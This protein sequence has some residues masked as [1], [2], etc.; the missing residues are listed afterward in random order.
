MQ[1]LVSVANLAEARDAVAGGAD[2]VDA[3]DPSTGALG[4]VTLDTLQEIHAAVGGR[5]VV[6]AALGDAT[7]ERRI[8][9]LAFDYASTGVGF[10]KVGFAG[11]T[12]PSCVERLMRAA[13]RGVRASALR[14]CG[15]IAVAYADSSGSGTTSVES[16]ALIDI[17]ARAG[18]G[19]VLLDT[20]DKRG[21]GLLRHVPR[22]QLES[23]VARAH[24]ARLTVALAGKLTASDLPLICTI[25]ADIAGVRG[26][27]CEDGRSSR[28]SVGKVRRL[29]ES[30]VG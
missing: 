28:V 25:G 23:W 18:A 26:A 14:N 21:P 24:E 3:K 5:R 9:H 16:T 17:A 11:V 7:D 29:T 22:A 20:A 27:A 30:L 1:L 4:A 6:S 15:V 2:I 8:E 19:G 10:V 13:I 12:A